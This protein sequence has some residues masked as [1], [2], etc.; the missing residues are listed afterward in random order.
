M[1]IS[2]HAAAILAQLGS[3]PQFLVLL[4]IAAVALGIAS[5]AGV[6]RRGSI[7]GRDRLRSDEPLVPVWI[8]MFFAL[9]VWVFVPATYTAYKATHSASVPAPSTA[10]TTTASPAPASQPALLNP[11]EMVVLSI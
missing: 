7:E 4:V 11:R 8:I 5:L 2:P 6:F 10:P 9:T 1:S 3:L